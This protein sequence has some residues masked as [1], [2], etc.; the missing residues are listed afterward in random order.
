[1]KIKA[2]YFFSKKRIES[3][4]AKLKHVAIETSN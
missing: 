2:K 1:M 3:K 4:G